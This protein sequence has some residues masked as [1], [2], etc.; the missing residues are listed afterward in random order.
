MYQQ[1]CVM[2]ILDQNGLMLKEDNGVCKLRFNSEYKIRL[3]NKNDFKVL[4]KVT[5]D[6]K[7]LTSMSESGVIIDPNSKVELERWIDDM[8]SGSKLK[9]VSAM[10]PD[11]QDPYSTQNGNIRV[12]FYKEKWQ[13]YITGDNIKPLKDDYPKGP[14]YPTHPISWECQ[15]N[16]F[17][18]TAY[19]ASFNQDNAGCTVNG[20][21]SDQSFTYSNAQFEDSV[22]TELFLR[23]IGYDVQQQRIPSTAINYCPN[24]GKRRKKT[25]NFCSKCGLSL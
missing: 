13:Y 22:Y 8:H 24:C 25:D 21:I 6:G 1:K 7:P 23:L 17:M 5:I 15:G 3:R 14:L 19:C 11:A 16:H 10:H 4:A 20:S 18:S 9:F 2:T 12:K